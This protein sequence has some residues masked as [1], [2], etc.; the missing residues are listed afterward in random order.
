M[1]APLRRSSSIV[2]SIVLSYFIGNRDLRFIRRRRSEVVYRL[3][4]SWVRVRLMEGRS[5]FGTPL[6]YENK[7]A[8]REEER[9]GINIK[10]DMNGIYQMIIFIVSE[11][12]VLS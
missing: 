3:G 11:Y 5:S 10:V 8:N 7:Q 9:E 1:D 2:I 6:F 4:F 12:K